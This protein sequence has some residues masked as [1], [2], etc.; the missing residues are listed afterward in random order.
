M[1]QNRVVVSKLRCNVF[2]GTMTSYLNSLQMLRWAGACGANPVA[3]L[4]PSFCSRS[5]LVTYSA[6][7]ASI[8]GVTF[9]ALMSSATAASPRLM[10]VPNP[11]SYTLYIQPAAACA[12]K[13][14]A[15][16]SASS[17]TAGIPVTASVTVRDSFGNLR[18]PNSYSESSNMDNVV[19]VMYAL[20]APLTPPY[21]FLN[22][23]VP[24]GAKPSL[25]RGHATP[26]LLP[27]HHGRTRVVTLPCRITVVQRMPRSP[28]FSLYLYH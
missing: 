13:S 5:S 21:N 10:S 16:V 27:G 14:T 15:S 2:V 19:A 28:A 1:R 11:V 26:R 8:N 25:A 6:L 18:T 20:P 24:S 9:D 4:E 7:S 22:G 23:F 3:V 12:T 17:M